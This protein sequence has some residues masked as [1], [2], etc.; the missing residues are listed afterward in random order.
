MRLEHR[1]LQLCEINLGSQSEKS[2]EYIYGCSEGERTVSRDWGVVVIGCT[3]TS[4]PKLVS[5]FMFARKIVN[6][7]QFA[8][9]LYRR[10]DRTAHNI[11]P[12]HWHCD[13]RSLKAL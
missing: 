4:D 5:Y 13:T 1:C 2:T 8:N 3:E 11:T 9:W 12:L 6:W 7:T 10:S